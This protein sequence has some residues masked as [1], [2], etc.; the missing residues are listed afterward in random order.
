MTLKNTRFDSRIDSTLGYK[1]GALSAPMTLTL[2]YAYDMGMISES[3]EE[4]VG[5]R[6]VF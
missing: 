6:S 3:D 2:L 4:G 5:R 1:R